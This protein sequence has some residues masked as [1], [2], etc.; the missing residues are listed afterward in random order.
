VAE[1]ALKLVY[2]FVCAMLFVALGVV[3]RRELAI[4]AGPMK[5]LLG[6]A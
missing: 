4:L 2:V 3:E 5:R 1:V 6:R